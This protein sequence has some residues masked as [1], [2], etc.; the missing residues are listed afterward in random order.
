MLAHKVWGVHLWCSS[1]TL[2]VSDDGCGWIRCLNDV[3]RA[4]FPHFFV[5]APSMLTS[6][7]ASSRF[8]WSIQ[9]M[10]SEEHRDTLISRTHISKRGDF[11]FPI[12]TL[13]IITRQGWVMK[14]HDW[15][16]LGYVFSLAPC[17]YQ[18]GEVRKS[19]FSLNLT[20]Q[21]SIRKRVSITRKGKR[22]SGKK[23]TTAIYHGIHLVKCL[24]FTQ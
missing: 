15:P 14:L 16:A 22:D 11:N 20:E 1:G 3:V 2:S 17:V 12:P 10:I 9:L 13:V 4:L 21:I 7:F 8:I 6:F 23:N 18:L 5:L 19:Q 24:P